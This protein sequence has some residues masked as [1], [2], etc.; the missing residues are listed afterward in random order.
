MD[1][2]NRKL[3]KLLSDGLKS[4]EGGYLGL[5]VIDREGQILEVGG[6]LCQLLGYYAEELIGREASEILRDFRLEDFFRDTRPV[7][8]ILR[9]EKT[10]ILFVDKSEQAIPFEVGWLWLPH[11]HS[12]VLVILCSLV[13]EQ[14]VPK[15]HGTL[16][17]S[18][19][20]K[21]LDDAG[22]GIG[23]YGPDSRL[24]YF[25]SVARA[26]MGREAESLYGKT[27]AEIY[28][29][30]F[31]AV[32]QGRIESALKTG[33]RQSFED[34]V[35]IPAGRLWFLST[36]VPIFRDS[37]EG[38]GVQ[39]I[40]QDISALREALDTSEQGQARLK[41]IYNNTMDGILL[42][43]TRATIADANPAAEQ[44]FGLT[45]E[46]L[47][48]KKITEL[49]E[50]VS[51]PELSW[52]PHEQLPH[53][54]ASDVRLLKIA[55]ADG[56]I[57]TVEER[58][59]KDILPETNLHLLR[60]MS[61]R[62]AAERALNEAEARNRAILDSLYA[63]VVLVSSTG[64][65]VFVNSVW[66]QFCRENGGAAGDYVGW[67][68]LE[69]CEKAIAN[70]DDSATVILEG[71]RNLVS[72]KINLFS[73][74][75]VCSTPKGDL[76]FQ[77]LATKLQDESN[78]IVIAHYDITARKSAET[79][80]AASRKRLDVICQSLPAEIAHIDSK[81]QYTFVSERYAAGMER[82]QSEFVMRPVAEI[83]DPPAFLREEKQLAEAF[84]GK[85]VS[86]QNALTL[87]SGRVR[88][89]I[90]ELI[91]DIGPDGKV[92]GC[93]VVVYDT[94]QPVTEDGDLSFA[95]LLLTSV[96]ENSPAAIAVFDQ[97]LKL[98]N[99]NAAFHDL[100][101]SRDNS[102]LTLR[103]ERLF[104][105]PDR[106]KLTG[107]A[108]KLLKREVE[109]HLATVAIDLPD[110]ESL[111]VRLILTA[112][113]SKSPKTSRVLAIF[114]DITES[115]ETAR[116]LA[117]TAEQLRHSQV[118]LERKN[119]ALQEILHSL[120]EERKAIR[121]E[122]C[123]SIRAKM[124]PIQKYLNEHRGLLPKQLQARLDDLIE[125]LSQGSLGQSLATLRGR[126]SP[127]EIQVCELIRQ[128]M[129]SKQIAD[130]LN[131]SV[132][133][134]SKHRQVIRRKLEIE[135]SSLNL[136]SYLWKDS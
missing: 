92:A 18:V 111:W 3:Y 85:R 2:K 58:I 129:T 13:G 53:L 67:N 61:I 83:L 45:L 136:A 118:E 63:S 115:V 89:L 106:A 98:E 66:R 122:T 32:I 104:R 56:S 114:A 97:E 75:Y 78:S 128:G 49:A 101:Q 62:A 44:M 119:S 110:G 51:D 79:N 16:E 71:L 93:F 25:N 84:A 126:L 38:V 29:R 120:E 68:Y 96:F 70:K 39:I 117:E 42:V 41:A 80:A 59:A 86:Y 76:S 69:V 35:A 74:E 40:S 103:F 26:L 22:N 108:R 27:A 124:E 36:Y 64:E 31:G 46:Q 33:N 77:M 54:G 107:I 20:E 123:E 37:G 105:S 1:R 50:R 17:P 130:K 34:Q 90:S 135:N 15:R 112:L 43:D 23:F 132:Q 4:A 73:S 109:R 10:S 88:E 125:K 55:R 102:D 8:E 133:T 131:L 87:K 82:E 65:I 9:G 72:N 47:L 94:S 6:I 7:A 5:L 116:N 95:E 14:V 24:H 60:D 52:Q 100:I 127:R 113:P 11:R 121:Q 30:K 21:L 134:V 81:L 48:G 12:E 57:L 19:I 28:G 91:P 99:A